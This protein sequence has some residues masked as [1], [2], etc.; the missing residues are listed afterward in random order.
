M[1]RR[2]GAPGSLPASKTVGA[3]WADG[4]GNRVEGLRPQTL[5]AIAVP[6][7]RSARNC[8]DSNRRSEA[9]GAARSAP[10]AG[11][12]LETARS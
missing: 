12:R 1:P 3:S 9:A 11:G 8:P 6:D 5:D 4:V 10:A 2:G 7:D